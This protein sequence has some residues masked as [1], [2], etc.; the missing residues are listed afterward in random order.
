[1]DAVVQISCSDYGIRP[2][3]GKNRQHPEAA[4]TFVMIVSHMKSSGLLKLLHYTGKGSHHGTLCRGRCL[5]CGLA[6]ALFHHS[7]IARARFFSSL[8]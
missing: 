6:S 5:L 7:Y 3:C 1:M 8:I 4:S 2:N